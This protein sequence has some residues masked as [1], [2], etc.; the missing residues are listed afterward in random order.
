MD[1]DS[2]YMAISSEKLEDIARPGLRNQFI[3]DHHNWFPRNDTPENRAYDKRTPGLFKEEWSGD[4]C[5]ALNS[6][7][8]YCFDNKYPTNDKYSSKGASKNTN[9]INKSVYPNALK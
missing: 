9:N 6:K 5:I 4:G 8:Y 7:T 3:Q 1:T 2:L